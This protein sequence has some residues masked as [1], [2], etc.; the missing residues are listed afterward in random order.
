MHPSLS[1]P[2]S[3]AGPTECSQGSSTTRCGTAH[4]HDLRHTAASLAVAAGADVT[5]VQKM[6]GHAS[7]A[8]ALDV[9]ADLFD[10]DLDTVSKAMGEARTKQGVGKLWAV[11]DLPAEDDRSTG[12]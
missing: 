7:A 8:T 11:P 3:S 1:V 4:P 10:D 6:L 9:Y 2:P 12:T 5:V